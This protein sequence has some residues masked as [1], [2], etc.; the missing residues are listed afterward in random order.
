M[1]PGMAIS[2]TLYASVTTLAIAI[3]A[4]THHANDL[5][6][7]KNKIKEINNTNKEIKNSILKIET[8]LKETP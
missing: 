3:T 7:I 4:H 8:K 2:I 1:T 6:N 5:N